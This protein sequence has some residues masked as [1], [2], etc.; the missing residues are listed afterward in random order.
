MQTLIQWLGFFKKNHD[1][2]PL[3]WYMVKCME[4]SGGAFESDLN[5]YIVNIC[6]K[7]KKIDSEIKWLT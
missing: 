3:Q 7:E 6:F 5:K 1:W 2:I 4:K